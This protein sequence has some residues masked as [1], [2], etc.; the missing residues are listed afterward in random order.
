VTENF[1]L[2][3]YSGEGWG[4]VGAKR[5]LALEDPHPVPPPEY[6]GRGKVPAHHRRR[7]VEKMSENFPLLRYSGGEFGWGP[8]V[9]WQSKTPTLSLPRSTRRGEKC[10]PTIDGGWL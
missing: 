4:G 1:P 8:N 9:G 6:Q 10:L 2:L 5:R 7:M 3:W